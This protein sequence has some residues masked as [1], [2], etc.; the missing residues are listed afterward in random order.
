MAKIKFGS[1]I[2]DS[3]GTVGGHTYTWTRYGN[4]LI[5]KPQTAKLQTPRQTA[6]RVNFLLLTKTWWQLLTVSQRDD[7][8]ALAAANPRPNVWGDDFP[9]TGLALFI[10]LNRRLQQAGLAAFDDAPADQFVTPPTTATLTVH[11]PSTASLAFTTTPAPT[12]HVA[13]LHLTGPI[14]PGISNA[15]TY[16][17]FLVASTTSQTSPWNIATPLLARHG[18][19]I[20]GRQ[21]AAALYFLNTDN[22][23]LSAPLTATT[24]AT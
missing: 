7:W 22:A 17:S 5:T 18:A 14:S 13:Y 15:T 21:Y 10:S 20:T 23:A 12:D 11:A 9:L 16:L 2:T 19:I 1:I 8:R 6:V 4:Q 24:I 3:R